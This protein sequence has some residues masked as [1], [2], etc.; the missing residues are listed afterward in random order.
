V[1]LVLI[2]IGCG[3]KPQLMPTPNLY[4]GD[5]LAP[6]AQV[7]PERLSN[8]VEVLYLTDRALEELADAAVG[9]PGVNGK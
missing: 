3:G 6:F 5:R 7:P 2:T 1:V 8:R 9:F 4:K